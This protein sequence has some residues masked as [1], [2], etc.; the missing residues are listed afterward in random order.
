[1]SSPAFLETSGQRPPHTRTGSTQD[2]SKIQA[3]SS[4]T[5]PA[6]YTVFIRLPFPRN[7]FVDPAPVEWDTVKDKALWKIISKGSDSRGIDWEDTANRFD[8]SLQF[9]MKQAAWLYERHFAGVR[10]QMQRL[11]TT[12]PS[13]GREGTDSNRLPPLSTNT[14][15]LKRT[16]SKNSS[17]AASPRP[18]DSP[19][20]GDEQSLTPRHGAPPFSRT[21]STATITQSKLFT[22]SR[23]ILQ[24]QPRVSAPQVRASMSPKQRNLELSGSIDRS[25]EDSDE[26]PLMAQSQAFRRPPL[27]SKPTLGALS[28]EGDVEDVDDDD[29][30]D[31]SSSAGFLPFATSTRQDPGA[32]LRGETRKPQPGVSSK[33]K[34]KKEVASSSASSASS[35]PPPLSGMSDS[36]ELLAGPKPGPLS[37]KH[38]AQLKQLSPR[39]NSKDVGSDGT[40]SMG[41]SFSDLDDAGISASAIEDAVLSTMQAGGGSIASRV[42]GLSQAFRSQR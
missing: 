31:E 6:G 8:V 5:P 12:T 26:E 28:S 11:A 36:R 42:S 40:P 24:R 16:G 19:V 2:R 15:L 30:E 41:S 21:P 22:S 35:M 27:S 18:R 32:T 10:K 25:S 13:A 33:G 20:P 23:G 29:D 9:L 7:D 39:S 14:S 1:M 38:R 37:P 4:P 34:Q 3:R 17:H